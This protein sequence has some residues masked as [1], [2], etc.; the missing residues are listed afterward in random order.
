VKVCGV[1]RV[2]DARYA[3]SLGAWAVGVLLFTTSPRSVSP[4]R[5][6]K[7]FNALSSSTLAVAVSNTTRRGELAQILSLSPDAIQIYHPFRLPKKRP[8]RVFRVWD[9]GRV[10]RDCDAVVIDESHGTGRPYDTDTAR[11]MVVES[12]VPV[13]LSG[14]LTADNVAAAIDRI[15]PC[16]VDVSSGVESSCGCKDHELLKRFFRATREVM[17]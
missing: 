4:Q 14:G 9:G 2:Q 7:I 17:A 15:H 6:E 5:A 10:T 11:R 3:V 1:T 13:I 16:A 12:P 8:Y